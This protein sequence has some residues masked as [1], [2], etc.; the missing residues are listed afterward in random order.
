MAQRQECVCL[1]HEISVALQLVETV[2]ESMHGSFDID[3]INNN[4][5]GG[6]LR[7]HAY[8]RYTPWSERFG[9]DVAYDL[10]KHEMAHLPA[11]EQLLG[12]EGIAEEVCFKLGETF[13]AAMSEEGWTRLKG[14]YDKMKRDHGEDGEVVRDCKLLEDPKTA[15]EFTQ[16]KGCLAAIVHPSGQV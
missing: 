6:Q 10:I 1:K 5:A 7:P 15:E 4:F 14:S 2:R 12:N 8:S 16:M 9:P 11:F 13:D 3:E